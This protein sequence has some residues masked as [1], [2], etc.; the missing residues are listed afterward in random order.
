MGSCLAGIDLALSFAR[1]LFALVR[2]GAVRQVGLYS[3]VVGQLF[4]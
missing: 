4:R 3:V 2:S 1:I